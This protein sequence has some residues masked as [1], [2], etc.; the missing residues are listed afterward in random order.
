MHSRHHPRITLVILAFA[1]VG[2]SLP[3]GAKVF[4]SQKAGL[5]LAFPSADRIDSETHILSSPEAEAIEDLSK[6]RLET[7]LVTIHTAW[8]GDKMLGYAH[9]ESHTVRTKPEGFMVVLSSEGKVK[10]VKVLAF[11]EPLDYLPTNRWYTQFTGMG[12]QDRVRVGRDVDAISGATLSARA[13]SAGVRR[14]LAYY[15]VLLH[16]DLAGANPTD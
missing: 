8:E 15:Q 16:P 13:A 11:W 2:L 3:A 14:M 9:I 6:S 7:R 10:E 4:H 1:L 5:E 12:R